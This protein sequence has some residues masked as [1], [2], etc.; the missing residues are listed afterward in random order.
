VTDNEGEN[1]LQYNTTP[2]WICVVGNVE[3]LHTCAQLAN[4]LMRRG[5]GLRLHD[6]AQA[7]FCP[8]TP[9]AANNL[10]PRYH[11][12]CQPSPLITHC[13]S[14]TSSLAAQFSPHPSCGPQVLGFDAPG[15]SSETR[16]RFHTSLLVRSFPFKILDLPAGL[17][18]SSCDNRHSLLNISR[19]ILVEWIWSSG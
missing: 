3:S 15:H 8:W 11:H 2:E 10:K 7:L 13:L 9:I 1:V 4:I 18:D 19:R 16:P 12:H 5:I 14:A 6:M 17:L